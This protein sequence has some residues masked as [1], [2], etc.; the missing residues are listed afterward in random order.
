MSWELVV[1]HKFA[2]AHF[3]EHYKGKCE[4]MHGHTFEMEV[5]LRAATLNESGISIDFTELKAFCA[6]PSKT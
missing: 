1:K 3:L 5:Y 2:A 4:R 6:P